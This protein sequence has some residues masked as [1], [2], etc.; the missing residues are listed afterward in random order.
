MAILGGAREPG[1][2]SALR[3]EQACGSKIAFRASLIIVTALLAQ[4]DL[5]LG[6]AASARVTDVVFPGDGRMGRVFVG[7]TPPDNLAM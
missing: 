3:S 6:C 7:F 2:G 4:H 1:F 5:R